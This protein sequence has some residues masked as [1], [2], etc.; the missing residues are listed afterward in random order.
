MINAIFGN[1]I[2]GQDHLT[3]EQVE[4]M[5]HNVINVESPEINFNSKIMNGFETESFLNGKLPSI[6][7][8]NFS[9]RVD[10]LT[11]MNNHEIDKSR[12]LQGN[13][14]STR[15]N[16]SNIN[17]TQSS[18]ID[19]DN[20]IG[21]GKTPVKNKTLH[22]NSSQ[23][24]DIKIDK[25]I[26]LHINN[27]KM[28][29]NKN[30]LKDMFGN[31]SR[32]DKMFGKQLNNF[33]SSNIKSDA[34]SK[35]Y[36]Q[37]MGEEMNDPR[38]KINMM[39]GN[40]F[41]RGV[42]RFDKTFSVEKINQ[43][44]DSGKGY[45]A[46]IMTFLSTNANNIRNK[47][48]PANVSPENKVAFMLGKTNYKSNNMLPT[49]DPFNSE[50]KQTNQYVKNNANDKIANFIGLK[51]YN[52]GNEIS[53]MFS[54]SPQ[55]QSD[56]N[57][58]NIITARDSQRPLTDYSTGLD[59]GASN[60]QEEQQ[61]EKERFVPEGVTPD[62]IRETFMKPSNEIM[63][64]SQQSESDRL[65]QQMQSLERIMNDPNANVVDVRSARTTYNA[66]L[67][68]LEQLQKFGFEERKYED[69]L[70]ERKTAKKSAQTLA[71][72]QLEFQREKFDKETELREKENKQRFIDAAFKRGMTKDQ[73]DRLYQIEKLKLERQKGK[74]DLA[75]WETKLKT[76]QSFLGDL[77]GGT[78]KPSQFGEIVGDVGLRDIDK[79]T[80]VTK[81]PVLDK[82]SLLTG[83]RGSRPDTLLSLSGAQPFGVPQAT[84]ADKVA[85]TVGVQ[86]DVIPFDQKVRDVFSS[87]SIDDIKR[88]RMIAEQELVYGFQQPMV[89][90]PMVQQP[91]MQEQMY[92]PTQTVARPQV[93]QPTMSYEQYRSSRGLPQQT[94]ISQ[95]GQPMVGYIPS[96]IDWSQMSPE[97]VA[98]YDPDYAE[99]LAQT[100][101]E[102]TY[103]RGPY[104][105]R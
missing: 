55:I 73:A 27:K 51:Q 41:N 38:Q 82:A 89:Q 56:V 20:I 52:P 44:Y 14:I 46:R 23:V 78:R 81:S 30:I 84:F 47:T 8:F 105:K 21:M 19:I 43:Y 5:R 60:E 34:T 18:N 22:N 10:S 13:N 42:Q 50:I 62:E 90:Q 2:L 70:A 88:E 54:Y 92:V 74:D 75:L 95:T 67:R 93:T 98:M 64:Q 102:T 33:M 87:K 103:R 31:V 9:N 83:T 3:N 16:F 17:I 37:N 86:R 63:M 97:E 65:M 45:G 29:K 79:T 69:V 72:K 85:M 40:G 100:K 91:I 53:R 6:E 15:D 96:D 61:V 99:Y 26:G 68:R 11:Y 36:K 77:V 57:S 24:K 49:Y 48:S 25:F 12:M 1:K 35:N 7:G 80:G 32:K 59:I 28:L 71:E 94:Y 104:K 39:L 101:G 4:D 58:R 66:L 76:G